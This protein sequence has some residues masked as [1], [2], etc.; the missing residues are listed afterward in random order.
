MSIPVTDWTPL[1]TDAR[2][3]DFFY[4]PW[5]AEQDGLITLDLEPILRTNETP[6]NL[7]VTLW[8]LPA[9]GESDRT[10]ASDLLLGAPLVSGT[11]VQQRMAGLARGRVYRLQVLVGAAGDQRAVTAVIVVEQ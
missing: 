2:S 9:Q 6:S 3:D 4:W 10:A 1:L 7:D 8:R 11:Q 5:V